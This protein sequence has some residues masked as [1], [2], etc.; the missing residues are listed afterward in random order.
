MVL[1]SSVIFRNLHSVKLFLN[2]VY[3]EDIFLEDKNDIMSFVDEFMEETKQKYLLE[4][5]SHKFAMDPE[6]LRRIDEAA[7]DK[8][9]NLNATISMRSQEL[10]R[11]RKTYE[12]LAKKLTTTQ[13]AYKTALDKLRDNAFKTLAWK[14]EWLESVLI[15]ITE[16][17][18][19]ITAKNSKSNTLFYAKNLE[20]LQ[21][22]GHTILF[23]NML[24][25][26]PSYAGQV[27]ID[28]KYNGGKLV[29]YASLEKIIVDVCT[30]P[31]DIEKRVSRLTGDVRARCANILASCESID[32]FNQL[33]ST[34]DAPGEAY[35]IVHVYGCRTFN[36]EWM[37]F[38]R[39]GPKV[40]IFF[41]IY[42]TT[43]E[44]VEI[45]KDFPYDDFP[46]ILEVTDRTVTRTKDHV[47][48]L[49]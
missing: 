5:N 35:S 7:E 36:E 24:A 38:I 32:E 34:Y 23:Q 26:H 21:N 8:K 45:A 46:E 47:L 44:L 17:Y 15:D 2:T 49:A 14:H 12:E 41:K 43:K 42:L 20:D 4:V 1:Y 18:T 30:S 28:Y 25:M 27:V 33:M 9:K 16:S 39:N 11:S 29:P 37:Q 40:G 22:M 31:E 6:V 13:D 19:K 48:K 3:D 10:E